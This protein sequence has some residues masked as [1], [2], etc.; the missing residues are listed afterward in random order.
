[1]LTQQL[2]EQYSPAGQSS[3]AGSHAVPPPGHSFMLLQSAGRSSSVWPGHRMQS[4]SSSSHD[5]PAQS[6]FF[7]QLGQASS[8]R[9]FSS[10]QSG[11]TA[12][13]VRMSR[14][15]SVSG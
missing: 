4:V 13:L 7:T 9:M 10:E 2:L 11:A 12:G 3:T 5:S 14:H 15:S 8:S 1:M 6:S